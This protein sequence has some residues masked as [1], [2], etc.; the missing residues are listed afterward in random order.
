MVSETTYETVKQ[1]ILGRELDF[2]SVKGRTEPLRTF[3]LIQQ[4]GGASD[5]TLEKFLECYA[6]GLRL[7]RARRWEEAENKFLEAIAY[8]DDDYPTRLHIERAAYFKLSPPSDDWNGVFEL[9]TKLSEPVQRENLKS[10]PLI[11]LHALIG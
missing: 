1:K 3:E 9:T 10:I 5:P 7:Y 2:I 8:R 4:R 11:D 6:D